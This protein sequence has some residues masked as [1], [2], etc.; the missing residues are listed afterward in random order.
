M[1]SKSICRWLLIFS[2][3]AF[4]GVT[5]CGNGD[6]KKKEAQ[7]PA[8]GSEQTQSAASATSI[9]PA[10]EASKPEPVSAEKTQSAVPAAGASTAAEASKPETGTAGQAKSAVKAAAGKKDGIAVSVD[11]KTLAKSQLDKEVKQ[12]LAIMK[13]QIPKDKIKEV[14]AAIKKQVV[15]GFILRTLMFNEADKRK[16]EITDNEIKAEMNQIKESL[17]QDKNVEAF[18][19]END[20]SQD[21]IILGVKVRKMV[22]QDLGA[23]AKPSET[24]IS[25]FYDD[26]KEKFVIPENAHVRHLLVAFAEG[27]DEKIKAEKKL[28]IENLR[29]Q[30][31]DGADF[32]DIAGKNSDCPSKQ[33]GGDLGVIGRGQT[34]KPFEDAAFSQE[35]NAVG[36]VVTTNYGYHIIQVLQR[37]E[38][39]TVALEELKDKISAYLEEQKQTQA[40][41]ALSKKLRE[42]ATIKIYEN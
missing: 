21:F 10:P 4:L 11:G 1:K 20:I 8:A 31:I 32:T 24:E 27:D 35:V 41:D 16:I 17:P 9:P 14:R 6:E 5:G 29:K 28:K 33:K 30:I 22:K 36:P 42:K 40:F 15:D 23:N 34:V 19:K 37:N 13:D 12:K 7:A 39:K 2:L 26:N 3:I 18:M 38:K 25:K